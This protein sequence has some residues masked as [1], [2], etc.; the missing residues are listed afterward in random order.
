MTW[1]ATRPEPADCHII[2]P[3]VVRDSIHRFAI[4]ANS[5][6]NLAPRQLFAS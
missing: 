2:W 5:S 3:L 6:R 1:L 4:D